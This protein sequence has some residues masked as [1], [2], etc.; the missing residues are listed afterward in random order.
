MGAGPVASSDDVD[1]LPTDESGA[2][3]NQKVKDLTI[4]DNGQAVHSRYRR[5]PN[6][7]ML[8]PEK[9]L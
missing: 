8:L 3:L 9:S 6:Y 5:T 4:V 7:P 1:S 2:R